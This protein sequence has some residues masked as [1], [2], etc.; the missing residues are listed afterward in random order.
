MQDLFKMMMS[1]KLKEKAGHFQ[2]NWLTMTTYL[3]RA[4]KLFDA[5]LYSEGAGFISLLGHRLCSPSEFPQPQE[6]SRIMPHWDTIASFQILSSLL[7][8]SHRQAIGTWSEIL[9]AL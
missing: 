2:T 6:K 7:F 5:D 9:T 8:T 3:I 1:S 4:T